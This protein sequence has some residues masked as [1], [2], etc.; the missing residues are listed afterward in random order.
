MKTMSHMS[1]LRPEI[2]LVNAG[3]TNLCLE[4]LTC[5]GLLV[6][7]D[8]LAELGAHFA[9]KFLVGNRG[10]AQHP[11][12]HALVLVRTHAQTHRHTHSAHNPTRH[13]S[14][15]CVVELRLGPTSRAAY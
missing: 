13:G 4:D 7:A 3:N 12:T 15:T 10:A 14:I 8:A 5:F 2:I 11:R 9:A 6:K 1:G